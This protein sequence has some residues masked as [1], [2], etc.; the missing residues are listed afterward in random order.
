MYIT[1][2][3]YIN[4]AHLLLSV[5]VNDILAFLFTVTIIYKRHEECVDKLFTNGV[6]KKHLS[7]RWRL[8]LLNQRSKILRIK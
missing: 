7:L 6:S 5:R 4:I 3:Q 8:C 1:N 2:E